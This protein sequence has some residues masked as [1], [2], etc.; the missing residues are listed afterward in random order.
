MIMSD[1]KQLPGNEID[2]GKRIS[3]HDKIKDLPAPVSAWIGVLEDF[4]SEIPAKGTK[5]TIYNL[6]KPNDPIEAMLLSQIIMMHE[7]TMLCMS[8]GKNEYK[9]A[10]IKDPA[11]M[12]SSAKLSTAFTKLIEN[13]KNYKGKQITQCIR[14]EQVKIESGAN[15]IVGPVSVGAKHHEP[16][17]K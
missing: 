5:T 14:V 6:M 9:K 10:S 15:A 4:A 2:E 3:K 1:N 12:K 11:F 7:L 8:R 16:K 13:Y 17:N